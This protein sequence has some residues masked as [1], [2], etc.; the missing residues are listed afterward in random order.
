MII[1]MLIQGVGD[2]SQPLVSRSYGAG[3]YAE[4]RAI[5]TTN[6]VIT[7]TIGVLGLA[8]MYLLREQVPAWFGASADTTLAIAFAL[9]VFSLSYVFYGFTHASTSYFYATD[10]AVASSTI[11]YG[12]AALVTMVVTGLGHAVRA[13]RHLG[14]GLGGAGRALDAGLR[15]L[16]EKRPCAQS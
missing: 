1:Q 9:P 4:A 15:F 12:E 6:Y 2:G 11:V 3:R 10:N 13:E 8:A 7:V 5:R 14:V 16:A